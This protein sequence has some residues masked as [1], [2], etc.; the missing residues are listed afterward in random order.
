[1]RTRVLSLF[2]FGSALLF[3]S[4]CGSEV[5][6]PAQIIS[7]NVVANAQAP[8][9]SISYNPRVFANLDFQPSGVKVKLNTQFKISGEGQI[10]VGQVGAMNA[11]TPNQMIQKHLVGIAGGAG[12]TFSNGVYSP[13]TTPF[14]PMKTECGVK[15]DETLQNLKSDGTTVDVSAAA[16]ATWG[17]CCGEISRGIQNPYSTTS[18]DLFAGKYRFFIEK[19][20][21][22]PTAPIASLVMKIVPPNVALNQVVPVLVGENYKTTPYVSDTTGEIYFAANDIWRQ[23]NEGSWLLTVTVLNP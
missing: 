2:S 4:A 8:S 21:C 16:Y 15:A 18:A 20:S 19:F 9:G 12:G 22:A 10:T 6:P 5:I 13:S 1:M 17:P 14:G 3:L 23:D 11:G 7:S